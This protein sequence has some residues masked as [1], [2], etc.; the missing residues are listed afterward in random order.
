VLALSSAQCRCWLQALLRSGRLLISAFSYPG[1]QAAGQLVSQ[2]AGLTF[3]AGLASH[4]DLLVAPDWPLRL[5]VY[6][7][8][9]LP[10]F[11]LPSSTG[12]R[13]LRM[14]GPQVC[15]T[16]SPPGCPVAPPARLPCAA[17]R[18]QQFHWLPM[19]EGRESATTG[20]KHAWVST[21]QAAP[22]LEEWLATERS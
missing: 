8:A 5:P 21:L 20:Q 15:S 14:W 10:H 9:W 16:A 3:L 17:S 11:C 2:V 4:S 12:H 13:R 6:L 18:R 22:M 1:S 19:A 7:A